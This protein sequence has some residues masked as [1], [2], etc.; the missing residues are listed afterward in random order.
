MWTPSS[1]SLSA[2]QQPFPP[3]SFMCHFPPWVPLSYLLLV[4]VTLFA[5]PASAQPHLSFTN[6]QTN[7]TIREVKM[8][9]WIGATSS[10]GS[11]MQD[12]VGT[13]ALLYGPYGCRFHPTSGIM[14]LAAA[15]TVRSASST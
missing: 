1:P 13:S 15:S 11:T 7:H 5:A 3:T 2:P 10:G 6:H 14:Y 8:E 9:H 12:G 4:I